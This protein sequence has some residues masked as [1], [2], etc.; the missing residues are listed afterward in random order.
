M[1]SDPVKFAGGKADA[2]KMET[3]M[4]FVRT[5]VTQ[6]AV[7]PDEADAVSPPPGNRKPRPAAGLPNPPVETRNPS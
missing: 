3:D 1:T 6:T 4:E 2:R 7:R 5:F